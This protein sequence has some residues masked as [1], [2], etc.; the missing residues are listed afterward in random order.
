MS[1]FQA[2]STWATPIDPIRAKEKGALLQSRGEVRAKYFR[3]TAIDRGWAVS[4]GEIADDGY[5]D[6]SLR[7]DHEGVETISLWPHPEYID[8]S[9]TDDKKATLEEENESP[10]ICDVGTLLYVLCPVLQAEKMRIGVFPVQDVF[11]DVL[12][13]QDFVQWMEEAL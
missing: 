1:G 4:L 8:V 3:T 2:L 5:G 7:G 11:A 9:L 12:D 6:L 10:L 13:P